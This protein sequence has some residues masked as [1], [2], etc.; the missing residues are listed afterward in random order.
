MRLEEM[1]AVRRELTKEAEVV[2]KAGGDHPLEDAR[3]WHYVWL[4]ATSEASDEFWKYE[5]EEPAHPEEQAISNR[6]RQCAISK[7]RSQRSWNLIH[8]LFRQ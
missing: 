7:T 8:T 3:P 2:R 6:E 1:P 5:L 4:R